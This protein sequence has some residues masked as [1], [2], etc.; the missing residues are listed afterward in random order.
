MDLWALLAE[1]RGRVFLRR[2]YLRSVMTM[3][4]S[5]FHKNHIFSRWWW[6]ELLPA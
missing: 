5:P 6:S 1:F 3:V 2:L 4:T